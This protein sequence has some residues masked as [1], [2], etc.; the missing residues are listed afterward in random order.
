M[1]AER[2]S[3]RAALEPGF[4]FCQGLLHRYMNDPRAAL[5]AFNMARRDPEWGELAVQNMVEIYLNPEHETNW[6]EVALDQR[7]DVPE[8]V[9]ASE[10]RRLTL[11]LTLTRRSDASPYPSL[12]PRP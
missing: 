6:D 5:R 2:S 1:Q 12:L 4:R 9:C 11:S 7:S 3:P 8:A 10:K